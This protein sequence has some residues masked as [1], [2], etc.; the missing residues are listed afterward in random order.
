M[1]FLSI[2][3]KTHGWKWPCTHRTPPP[4]DRNGILRAQ[5]QQQGALIS[6]RAFALPAVH[7]APSTIV[8]AVASQDL[9]LS[10]WKL[11]GNLCQ[12]LS[13]YPID[14]F[15]GSSKCTIR[16]DYQSVTDA[17]LEACE[18]PSAS[19]QDALRKQLMVQCKPPL[20]PRSFYIL[21]LRAPRHGSDNRV[22]LGSFTREESP[23]Q[24]P[25]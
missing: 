5:E 19:V 9:C 4:R 1:D 3:V 8:E 10:R 13:N 6:P 11:G 22:R 25:F 15:S 20:I 2:I 23:N 21:M 12:E 24:P 14:S 17:P 18:S 16:R 7:C